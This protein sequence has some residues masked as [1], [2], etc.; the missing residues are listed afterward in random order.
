MGDLEARVAAHYSAGDLLQAID[1][2]LAA[3]GVAPEDATV[4]TLAPVDEFH[5]AG[6]ATT[7]KLLAMSGV[8]P[9]MRVLDAGSGIG[10]AARVLAVESG[11]ARLSSASR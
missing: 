4:A 1:E 8:Q 2:G 6:R 7:L 10:G 9:G 5:T 11:S 3:L